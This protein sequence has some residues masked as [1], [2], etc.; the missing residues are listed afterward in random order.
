MSGFRA[1]VVQLASGTVLAQ[2]ISILALPVLT[3]LYPATDFGVFV[4]F[5]AAASILGIVATGRYEVTILS[6][7]ND[8][9]ARDAFWLV[10][11]I[12]L[13]VLVILLVL[14]TSVL[15][16]FGLAGASFSIPLIAVLLALFVG[17]NGAY[18]AL[19]CWA[20][21]F[22][23]YRR[24][25]MNRIV[26]ALVV[27]VASIAFGILGFGPI[28]LI[29]GS[30]IGQL[31]NTG[32]LALQI[33]LDDRSVA[34]PGADRILATAKARIDFPK[35]LIFS[36][37]LERSSAELHVFLLSG[38][39]GTSIA[40]SIGIYRRAVSVPGRIVGQAIR[41]VFRQQAAAKLAA[42]G[43]CR[44]L[45]RRVALRLFLIGLPVFLVLLLFGPYLFPLVF[46]SDWTE[47]GTIAQLLS[48][49]FLVMFVTSPLSSVILVGNRPRYDIYLQG[50]VL[51]LAAAALM[52]GKA[53]SSAYLAVFLFGMAHCTK[54]LVEFA[55]SYRIAAGRL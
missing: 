15:Q 49:M 46:G 51:V 20:N 35:F 3:R 9:Q 13:A 17:L 5:Q 38:F 12:S 29:A 24:L 45:F 53:L 31:I 50:L 48:P 16:L 42:N 2:A 30:V 36:G 7:E 55:V 4:I 43:E 27:A 25:A 26:R 47:A 19:Y 28:G 10:L 21:R 8:D 34:Y 52:V 23:N 22:Q 41:H 1:N 11:A 14:G 44:R 18:Q 54:S 6:A 39:F 32:L 33:G 40:G 37:L